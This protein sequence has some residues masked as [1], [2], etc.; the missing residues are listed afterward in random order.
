MSATTES[1]STSTADSSSGDAAT[2]ATSTTA[3]GTESTGGEDGCALSGQTGACTDVTECGPGSLSVLGTCD[4]VPSVQCCLDGAVSCSVDAAP[5]LCLPVAQC[6]RGLDQTPG[7][8]PGAADVQCCSDPAG[9]CDPDAAPLP[10][11]GLV[12]VA[13]DPTCPAGMIAIDAFCIDR[14]EASLVVVDGDGDV[15]SSHS[16]YV[17]PVV[18]VRAVSIEG[19]VPQGY[20]DADTA[21]AACAAADKRLCTDAEWL[22]ACRGR[23]DH[24]YPY[25]DD[26]EPGVCNDARAQHP[27]VEYFGTADAWIW[28]QLGHP[29]ILQVPDGVQTTG[30][31]PGCV[32]DDG[33]FDMV[34]NLHEWTADPAGTFRGGFFVDTVLNGPGCGYA[35]TA[36]DRSHWDY[37]TGFRCCASPT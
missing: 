34:G 7:L 18:D 26:L 4:D 19:A 8:C 21:A 13:W 35:T 16:P 23:A 22:R 6:P 17:H 10:N 28:S 36:H 11:E 30:A 25:G 15:V 32:S 29:C 5:G 20:V 33:A 31:H 37:S 14:H 9:A 2:T 27:A 1:P 12:E 24:T 3:S